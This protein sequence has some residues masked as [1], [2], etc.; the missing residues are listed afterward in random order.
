MT[1]ADILNLVSN[2][3]NIKEDDSSTR[4]TIKNVS[5]EA[6]MILCAIDKRIAN[7]YIPIINGIATIPQTSLGVLKCTPPLDYGDK[8]YG[9]SIVTNK[10][11]VLEILYFYARERLVEDEDELDLHITLQQALI[12]YV[13]YIVCNGNGEI[14][15]GESFYNAYLRNV[16][17]FEMV[18]IAIPET[19]MEV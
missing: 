4:V 2:N 17:Q 15:Q 8:I 10:T 12:N 3:L 9:N 1:L 6:Y 16:S 14:S 11:G 13:C 5:N 19:V 18:D 7:A